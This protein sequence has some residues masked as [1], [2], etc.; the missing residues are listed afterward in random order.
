[1]GEELGQ[2]AERLSRYW[3]IEVTADVTPPDLSISDRVVY[4][5]TRIVR[6]SVANAVRHGGARRVK[7]TACAG[8]ARLALTIDD[9]GRG[10]AFTGAVGA[11]E[12]ASSGEAPRSLSE[13]VRA[14]N[15]RLELRSSSKGASVLI[16]VPLEAA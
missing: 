4:D 11:A 10:F 12:L 2:L 3:T 16:D 6:E 13:R 1:V 14:L 8:D 7:V 15:G 5:L 9:D